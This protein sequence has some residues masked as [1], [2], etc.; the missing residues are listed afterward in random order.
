[1]EL[2]LP[3]LDSSIPSRYLNFLPH[4][5]NLILQVVV[6]CLLSVFISVFAKNSTTEI[7]YAEQAKHT[8]DRRNISIECFQINASGFVIQDGANYTGL[9]AKTFKDNTFRKPLIHLI[10]SKLNLFLIRKKVECCLGLNSSCC[11]F[12]LLIFFYSMI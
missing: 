5:L 8:F 11:C 10:I 6:V 9:R 12:W 7:E 1:M 4:F 3:S 2:L